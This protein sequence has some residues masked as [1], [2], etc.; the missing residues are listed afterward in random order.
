MSHW[1]WICVLLAA[2]CISYVTLAVEWMPT[3]SA[4]PLF[5]SDA[6]GTMAEHRLKRQFSS[7]VWGGPHVDGPDR[8]LPDHCAW[9]NGVLV[10]R[11]HVPPCTKGKHDESLPDILTHRDRSSTAVRCDPL[12]DAQSRK[13]LPRVSQSAP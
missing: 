11:T 7:R 10:C 2:L 13:E 6:P 5:L 9:K 1:V 12:S 4:L 3:D 8:C